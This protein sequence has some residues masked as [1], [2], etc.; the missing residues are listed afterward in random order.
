MSRLL[1]RIC[2]GL[3]LASLLKDRG[4]AGG[5]AADRLDLWQRVRGGDGQKE[6]QD[7]SNCPMPKRTGI[8]SAAAPGPVFEA[9]GARTAPRERGEPDF[10]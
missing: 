6:P 7:I 1:S 8:L 3:L 9:G 10:Y 4:L 5:G 2:N